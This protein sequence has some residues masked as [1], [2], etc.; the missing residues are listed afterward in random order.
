ML[1]IDSELAH[2]GA[3]MMSRE[4]R[5]NL[6]AL[7][8]DELSSPSSLLDMCR[9]EM[10]RLLGGQDVNAKMRGLPIPPSL[11]HYLMFGTIEYLLEPVDG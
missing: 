1:T 10:R 11:R 2:R 3:Q 5:R 9:G 7:L 4:G 6:L 8:R